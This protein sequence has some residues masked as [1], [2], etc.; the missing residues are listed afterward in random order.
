[1]RTKLVPPHEEARKAGFEDGWKKTRA[2]AGNWPSGTYGHADYELGY[3]MSEQHVPDR[4]CWC[5]PYRDDSGLDIWI[6]RQ[7]RKQ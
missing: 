1:M 4:D 6:H 7:E 3:A 5:G 2:R